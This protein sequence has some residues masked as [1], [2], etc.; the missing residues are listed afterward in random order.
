VTPTSGLVSQLATTVVGRGRE[1][2]VVLAALDA[3]RHVLLEGPP[4]TG[5]STLLRAIAEATGQGF[6]FVEGNAELTPARLVGHFD[7]A[8]VL[9]E[10][11][12]EKVFVDGPLVA[13]LRAG[14]LLYVEELNRVPEDTLNTLITV[15]SEGELHVPRLGRIVAEPG[16]HLVAAMNPFDAVG[17]AR[18]SSAVYDRC[19]RLV[20]D[21]QS[22]PDEARIVEAALT[23]EHTSGAPDDE[24]QRRMVE[25]VRRTRTHP[26]VRVGSS[27]RG[28]IDATLVAASLSRLRGLT[29]VDDGVTL[30]AA[31]VAL[32]GR[33][34]VREGSTRTAD[35]IVRALVA[36]VFAAPAPPAEGAPGPEGT[37]TTPDGNGTDGRPPGARGGAEPG[38]PDAP[39]ARRG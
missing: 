37:G 35:D 33:V 4:G 17:T 15:M 36:E 24:W 32:S 14:A 22:A 27:V 10:G 28:A 12:S 11:Y 31:L 19:C 29:K 38:K 2:E 30:D 18:I 23:A 6:E 39:L 26:D 5:K 13:A 7:P 9:S 8:L 21:Y 3:G 25:V 1:L 16:F 20:V 34:R